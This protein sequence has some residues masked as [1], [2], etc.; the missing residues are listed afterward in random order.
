MCGKSGGARE[1]YNETLHL[2]GGLRN[3]GG[4]AAA[5]YLTRPQVSVG[6]RPHSEMIDKWLLITQRLMEHVGAMRRL[7]M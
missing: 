5:S 6:V 7:M 1:R 4:V 2:S 3:C